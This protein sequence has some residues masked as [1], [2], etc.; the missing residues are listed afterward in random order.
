MG[1]E[2]K[3]KIEDRRRIGLLL[4]TSRR[5]L[6][7]GIVFVKFIPH[8]AKPTAR[9]AAK[10]GGIFKRSQTRRVLLN[11]RI[12]QIQYV[13]GKKARDMLHKEY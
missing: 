11:P 6:G 12:L 9:R 13:V 5:L 7:G 3:L 8:I 4:I 2:E 10:Y 1:K